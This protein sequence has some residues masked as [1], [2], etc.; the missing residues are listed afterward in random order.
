M[1]PQLVPLQLAD[2]TSNALCIL[3]RPGEDLAPVVLVLPAMGVGASYYQ[4]LLQA[5]HVSGLTA[6]VTDLRG[7]GMSSVRASRQTD[8]GYH[9][10]L[11]LDLDAAVDVLRRRLPQRRLYLLGHSLGGELACLHASA[12]PTDLSGIILVASG[13]DYH[14]N[15]SFPWSLGIYGFY[16]AAAL[17]ARIW[18]YYPGHRLGFAGRE[19]RTTMRDLAHNGVTGRF[20]PVDSDVDYEDRLA[21]MSLPVLA[22]TITDDTWAPPGATT[23]LLGKMPRSEITRW[24]VTPAELGARRLGHFRWVK[25]CQQL[26]ERIARWVMDR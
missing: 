5:L 7:I 17:I 26:A 19:A 1:E 8:F 4:S 2:G 22:V 23:H 11:T 20:E 24:A 25:H 10:M 21:S 15:W 9:E 14:G 13:T 6:A 3:Q 16:R 12:H 18:G